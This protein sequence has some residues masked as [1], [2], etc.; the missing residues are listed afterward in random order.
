MLEI[1]FSADI[2]GVSLPIVPIVPIAIG[3]GIG[4]GRNDKG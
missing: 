3:I 4:N 2:K 1:T